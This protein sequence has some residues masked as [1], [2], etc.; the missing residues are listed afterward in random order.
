MAKPLIGICPSVEHGRPRGDGYFLYVSYVE[1]VTRA[2]AIPLL[3]PLARTRED[4]IEILDRVDGLLLTGGGDI[5]PAL[6]GQTARHSERVG[7]RARAESELRLARESLE[8]TKAVLGICLG[9]QI[10]NVAFGGTLLQFIPEDVPG[11]LRHEDA[12]AA[13]EEAPQHPVRLEAETLLRRVLGAETVVV[14]SFHH[15]AVGKLA[16]GFRVA[17][18][19]PE[20]IVEAIERE[21]HPFYIGVQWHPERMPESPLSARLLRAFVDAAR[22]A[23]VRAG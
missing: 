18:R 14:N 7:S 16:P 22:G 3:L 13:T 21:D 8:R 15:Q 5:D 2:G 12:A 4:A 6:Y 1:A 20:G 9:V 11:A 17:A 19:S 10:M 23:P